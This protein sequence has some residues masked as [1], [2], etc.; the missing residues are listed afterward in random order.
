M[1]QEKLAAATGVQNQNSRSLPSRHF[2]VTSSKKSSLDR[3]KPDECA[4]VGAAT[5]F[6]GLPFFL[7][8]GALLSA[9]VSTLLRKSNCLVSDS[10]QLAFCVQGIYSSVR[11]SIGNCIVLGLIMPH[12]TRPNILGIIFPLFWQCLVLGAHMVL[13]IFALYSAAA[14]II[15]P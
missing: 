8:P 1:V 12:S 3:S 14:I 2:L 15:A 9:S 13:G 10:I 5:T 7:R 11:P 6:L 4:V